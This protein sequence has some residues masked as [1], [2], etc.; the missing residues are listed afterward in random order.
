[1]DGPNDDARGP[2]GRRGDTEYRPRAHV[3]ASRA[4]RIAAKV[5]TWIALLLGWAR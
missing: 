5:A 1:M 4:R 3:I 2:G